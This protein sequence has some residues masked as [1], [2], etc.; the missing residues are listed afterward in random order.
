MTPQALA[1]L[2]QLT[3]AKKQRELALLDQLLAEERA[4]EAEIDELAAT[5]A[6]DL[7]AGEALPLAQQAVRL[8]WADQR[9]RVARQRQAALAPAIR[10]ARA[11]AAQSLGKHE[12][13]EHLAGR[14]DRTARQQRDARAEREAPPA[15][16]QRDG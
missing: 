13:L 1:R 12:A 6:R 9:M 3:S 5:A 11:A 8:A 14:A 2:L 16:P 10:A 15:E 4:L 7:E